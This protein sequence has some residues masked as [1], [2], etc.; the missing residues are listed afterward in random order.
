MPGEAREA[1]DRFKGAWR[2]VLR[3]SERGR[4]QTGWS[5]RG[6]RTV[7]AGGTDSRTRSATASTTGPSRGHADVM[8]PARPAANTRCGCWM[9]GWQVRGE[10]RETGGGSLGTD[11]CFRGRSQTEGDVGARPRRGRGV[12]QK[13]DRRR[14]CQAPNR[15]RT[16]WDW[17]AVGSGLSA[18]MTTRPMNPRLWCDRQWL[19][20]RV[21][22]GLFRRQG[23]VRRSARRCGRVG[24]S[25]G[26]RPIDGG[27]PRR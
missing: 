11:R 20:A 9:L 22:A 2:F 13:P 18:K 17:E 14:N 10:V 27:D 16:G 4:R 3:G 21:R 1:N 15:V 25:R 24:C 6:G 7:A 19:P 5:P 8:L 23:T 12:C 26:R